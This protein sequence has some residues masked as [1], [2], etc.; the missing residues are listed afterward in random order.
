[1]YSHVQDGSAV[2]IVG[3]SYAC[4]RKL[5]ALQQKGL[6]SHA[7]VSKDGG[8]V[9]WSLSDWADRIKKNFEAHYFVSGN[10]P[11]EKRPGISLKF[12]DMK[13]SRFHPVFF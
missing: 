10:N 13:V 2:E 1:M 4:L 8:S 6:Y 3:L 11:S 5:A 7:G 12:Y 9:E